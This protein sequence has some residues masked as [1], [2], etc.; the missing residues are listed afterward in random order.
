MME[1]VQSFQNIFKIPELKRRVLMSLALLA[2][3]RLGA[4]VP[5]PGIDA[6]ALAAAQ[7]LALPSGTDPADVA[8]DYAARN[9][10]ILTDCSCTVGTLDATV[11]VSIVVDGF[12]L[13]TGVRTVTARARAVVD[14]PAE[15]PPTASSL[16]LVGA[17]IAPD[18]RSIVRIAPGHQELDRRPQRLGA[19]IE[20]ERHHDE[21]H[22]ARDQQGRH[23]HVGHRE[24]QHHDEH[25][26]PHEHRHQE[27]E[28][29]RA[30]EPALLALERQRAERAAFDQLEPGSEDAAF[31]TARTALP[32]PSEQ[33][34][35]RPRFHQER[36]SARPLLGIQR[37]VRVTRGGP[38]RT[39]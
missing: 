18:R 39:S 28:G 15:P 27:V 30:E 35:R 3:Y 20:P 5:T 10:A 29:H 14:L 6:A 1:G 22:G 7:E 25:R 34:G 19:R 8:A 2:A 26:H 12:L 32:H 38:P 16:Q 4:H 11:T 31:A 9:D 37:A 36:L 33:N 21:H 24:H 23:R 17:G 13:V